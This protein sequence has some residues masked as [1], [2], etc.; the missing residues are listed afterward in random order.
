MYE[1]DVTGY[2]N[3]VN[4]LKLFD[5]DSVDD[6]IVQDDSIWF[7][8]EEIAKNLTLFLYPDDSDVQGQMLRIYQQY[9]MVSNA[10]QLILDE[11]VAK[12]SNLYDLPDY[13]VVQI[14]DTHP[15][16]VI[17]ELIRLLVNHGIE[18]NDAIGIVTR[19]CAYTNHTILAEALEKWPMWYLEKVVPQL[20]P[21]IKML[22][23]KVKEKYSDPGVAIIDENNTV[24]MAHI[25]IHYSSSVNGVAYLH[26]EI[27]KNSELKPFYDLYPEKF[28]NKT[29][30]I[31][32]RRWLLHCNH[33]LTDYISGKIGPD[34]KKDASKLEDLLKYKDDQK[35]LDDI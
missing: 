20:V 27:L 26:T 21:I 17:P 29:N 14:N 16:M 3:K 30:G 9:F 6:S 22:D 7:N 5:L 23:V 25:D 4:T 13:A 18:M 2:D 1:I 8:K 12:G 15:T 19:M 32:F 34:F 11:A 28:N 35:V 24:H 31:T 10:A 33:Q